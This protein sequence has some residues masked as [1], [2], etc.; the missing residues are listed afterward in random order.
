MDKP[1][2]DFPV[3]KKSINLAKEISHLCR[4]IKVKEAYFLKDQLRRAS[5]SIVLNIAEGA[6]K[7]TKRDKGSFYRISRGS[8]Y[9]CL[10]AIDLMCAFE[11]IDAETAEILKKKLGDISEDLQKLIITIERRNK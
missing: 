6:G 9:E 3:Y 11:Q 1:F 4:K 10:A 8:A 7:W 2:E 5:S